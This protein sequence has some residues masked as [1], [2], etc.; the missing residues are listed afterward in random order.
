MTLEGCCQYPGIEYD[1]AVFT[2]HPENWKLKNNRKGLT[3][4][5]TVSPKRILH[6]GSAP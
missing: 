1:K 2:H 6:T 3:V 5:K 4:C